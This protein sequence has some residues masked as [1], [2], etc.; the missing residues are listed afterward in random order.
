MAIIFGL[1]AACC[2]G[3][4]DF[5]GGL[6]SRR[7]AALTASMWGQVIGV[8]VAGVALLIRGGAL[9]AE[10]LGW[11]A[12]AGIGAGVGT[13]VLYGGLASG[14][15]SVVAPLSGLAAAAIPVVFGTVTGDELAPLTVAG[16]L[17]ALPAVVL[18]SLQ[19]APAGVQPAHLGVWEGLGSGVA[20]ALTF[21]SLARAGSAAGGWPPLIAAVVAAAVLGCGCALTR[22]ALGV[23]RG[24]RYL[25]AALG[26]LG[27]SATISYSVA[28]AHGSLSVVAVLGALYP[29]LTVVCARVFLSEKWSRVQIV[30]LAAAALAA[31]LIAAG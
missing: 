25:V 26:F 1:L 7:V 20:F 22:T 21:V 13:A 11:G 28:G 18:V 5:F 19:R 12:L 27:T 14:R 4:S 8:P 30:G 6:A 2:Y 24:A 23:P 16:I 3:V 9:N 17:L 29:A 15:M 10:T 31:T